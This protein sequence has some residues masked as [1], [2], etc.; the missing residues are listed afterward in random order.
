MDDSDLAGP[1]LFCGLFGTF[2]LLVRGHALISEKVQMLTAVID[3]QALVRLRLRPRSSRRHHIELHIQYD[4]STTLR[5]R[6]TS[7]A[8]STQ[9]I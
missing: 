8:K 1:F 9:L 3:R 6:S 7:S 4:V 5:G 2:L